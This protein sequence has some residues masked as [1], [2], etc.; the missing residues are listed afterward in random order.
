[1]ADTEM[2]SAQELSRRFRRQAKYL[3]RLIDWS[4]ADE[5]CERAGGDAECPH[6]GLRLYD[7]PFNEM[8]HLHVA[9]DG[10]FLHL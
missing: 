9:C 2:M 3:S 7:H 10:R 1:M 6:C 5:L 4:K 8:L